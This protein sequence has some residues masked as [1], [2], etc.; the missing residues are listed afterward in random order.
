[1][2]TLTMP[3][4]EKRLFQTMKEEVEAKSVREWPSESVELCLVLLLEIRARIA[5]MLQTLEEV[6]A[7][8]VEARSFVVDSTPLLAAAE[9]FAASIGE[10]VE[11]L[12][13]SEGDASARLLAA[14]RLLA[15]EEQTYRNLLGKA[16]S[17]AARPSPPLD[18]ERI[19]K[20]EEAY[21][22]GDTKPFHRR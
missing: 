14:L 1:M 20:A 16:A 12:S 4:F 18:R 5:A 6:L 11:K 2:T 7:E 21:T 19:R 9:K 22:C 15:K 17:L 3:S 10:L 13:S 8:G